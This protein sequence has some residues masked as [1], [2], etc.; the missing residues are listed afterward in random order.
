[1]KNTGQYSGKEVVM[2]S[3]TD[4]FASVTPDNKR[5]RRFRK[6]SLEWGETKTLNFGTGLCELAFAEDRAVI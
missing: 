4:E 2:L 6:I 3:S 5:L 1:V